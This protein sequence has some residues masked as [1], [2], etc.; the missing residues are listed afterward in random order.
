[1]HGTDI[2]PDVERRLAELEAASD[3]RR[4][5]L[6]E[7]MQH[8]PAEVSRRDVVRD[9]LHDLRVDN[10][11]ASLVRRAAHAVARASHAMRARVR[12]RL[13]R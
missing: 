9:S 11:P 3:A 7:L 10:D 12:A 2:E 13:G 5:D 6:T 1:M 4:R 8:L